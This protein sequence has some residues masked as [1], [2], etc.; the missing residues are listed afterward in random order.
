MRTEAEIRQQ[1]AYWQNLLVQVERQL[2]MLLLA[3]EQA[4]QLDAALTRSAVAMARL[5]VL[6]QALHQAHQREDTALF[7]SGEQCEQRLRERMQRLSS[8]HLPALGGS[9]DV[10]KAYITIQGVISG[11]TWALNDNQE[12]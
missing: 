11:L 12:A 8:I 9:I 10:R 6:D 1:L 7:S 2:Q 3:Q 5:S 4:R